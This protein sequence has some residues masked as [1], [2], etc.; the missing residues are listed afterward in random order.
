LGAKLNISHQIQLIAVKENEILVKILF[1]RYREVLI[2]WKRQLSVRPPE[3]ASF[4]PKP[5]T[6]EGS[7]GTVF[8]V[9]MERKIALNSI[10]KHNNDG[11]IRIQHYR[12]SQR[13][14]VCDS[15]LLLDSISRQIIPNK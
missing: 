5:K 12:A 11:D 8:E 13:D 14:S 7:I 10:D 1:I 6:G 3:S 2:G 4:S 15:A 9:D